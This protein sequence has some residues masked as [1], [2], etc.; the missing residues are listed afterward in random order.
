[1]TNYE[2]YQLQWMLDHDISL[3]DLIDEMYHYALCE[4]DEL[5]K[6]TP[7]KYIPHPASEAINNSYNFVIHKMRLDDRQMLDIYEE[8]AK[9]G[10]EL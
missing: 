8:D 1:M 10:K 7:H 2:K 3:Q 4:L 9:E 6:Y 5:Y